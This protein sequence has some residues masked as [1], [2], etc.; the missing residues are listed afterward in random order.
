[1]HQPKASG[2]LSPYSTTSSN[3]R[4]S[5]AEN[6]RGHKVIVRIGW[7]VVV[8]TCALNCIHMQVVVHIMQAVAKTILLQ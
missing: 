8:T 3:N 4:I 6:N 7:R 2:R 5:I 1:M